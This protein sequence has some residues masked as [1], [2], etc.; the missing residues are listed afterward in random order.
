LKVLHNCNKNTIVKTPEGL[1]PNNQAKKKSIQVPN[2][3]IGRLSFPFC[4]KKGGSS[5]S[6]NIFTRI[7]KMEMSEKLIFFVVSFLDVEG[8]ASIKGRSLLVIDKR[9]FAA[10]QRDQGCQM[11]CFQSK[12]TNL[13]KF[14][15][16]LYWKMF[17]YFMDIWNILCR[18]GIF[19]DHLVHFV[20][21]WYLFSGFG[22][23]YQ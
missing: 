11:V 14:W 17:I 13:G 16:A 7:K 12:K 2:L 10:P 9:N 1:A 15:K 20:L 4:Q 8:C 19:Y 23:M 6:S 3:S 5:D 18:F 22:I 21:I